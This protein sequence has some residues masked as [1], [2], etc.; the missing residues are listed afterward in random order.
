MTKTQTESSN[1]SEQVLS[2]PVSVKDPPSEPQPSR[3]AKARNPKP[4]DLAAIALW[5]WVR[6][7]P[8]VFF[9]SQSRRPI[10]GR[11]EGYETDVSAKTGGQ[12][13]NVAVRKEIC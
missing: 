9:I 3:K 2:N 12:V 5:L 7:L 10:S 6:C 13:A 4:V 8:S 1:N 11:I